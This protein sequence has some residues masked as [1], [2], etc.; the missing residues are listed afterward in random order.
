VKKKEKIGENKNTGI[1]KNTQ[2][3]FYMNIFD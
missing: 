1:I 3:N 2:N